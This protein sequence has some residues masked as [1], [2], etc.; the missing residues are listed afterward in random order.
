MG[1]SANRQFGYDV[2][3]LQRDEYTTVYINSNN[4]SV[5]KSYY[6][7]IIKVLKGAD[8]TYGTDIL[9]KAVD[10]SSSVPA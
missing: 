6:L 10:L 2:K 4:L 7:N 1:N 8:G 9:E 3:M 5:R